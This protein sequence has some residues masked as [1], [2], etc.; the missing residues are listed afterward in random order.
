MASIEMDPQHMH[1][2]GPNAFNALAVHYT[3]I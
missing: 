3:R 2:N 1:G